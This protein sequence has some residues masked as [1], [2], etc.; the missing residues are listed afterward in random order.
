M[1]KMHSLY[2]ILTAYRTAIIVVPTKD[3]A[4]QAI[5]ELSKGFKF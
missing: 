2:N 4:E 1:K 3:E 5:E